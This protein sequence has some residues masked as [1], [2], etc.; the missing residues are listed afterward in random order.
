ME[1]VV[2]RCI[3]L[4]ILLKVALIYGSAQI[5]CGTAQF[6][7]ST[8]AGIYIHLTLWQCVIPLV[9]TQLRSHALRFLSQFQLYSKQP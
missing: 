8:V 6:K 3:R 4:Q 5:V 7:I 2:F 1:L 9:C